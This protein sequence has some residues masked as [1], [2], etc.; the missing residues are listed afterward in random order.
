MSSFEQLVCLNM[1][2]CPARG[3]S[4]E[5]VSRRPIV[6]HFYILRTERNSKIAGRNT[7]NTAKKYIQNCD[8]ERSEKGRNVTVG[9][10]DR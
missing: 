2:A 7:Q 4:P 6:T 1:L 3:N 8:I 9:V 10:T 5:A